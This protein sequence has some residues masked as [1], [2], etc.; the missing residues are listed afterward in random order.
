MSDGRIVQLRTLNS[1]FSLETGA[2]IAI[3]LDGQI[4]APL[5]DL[6]GNVIQLM[7]LFYIKNMAH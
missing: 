3:E 2:A 5:H 1:Y 7:E 6:Y 4:F